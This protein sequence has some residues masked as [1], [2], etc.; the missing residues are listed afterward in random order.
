MAIK[1]Y[2]LR[3][4][5]KHTPFELLAIYCERQGLL[6]VFDALQALDDDNRG[7]TDTDFQDIHALAYEGGV[8]LLIEEAQYES[9]GLVTA[10]EGLKGHHA[11]AFFAF[12]H[13][14]AL[15]DVALALS[16]RD[17]LTHHWRKRRGLP[18]YQNPDFTANRQAF[19]NA[20]GQYFQSKEGRGRTRYSC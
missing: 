13:H 8:R 5:L 7:K 20:I 18:Q 1:H 4:F 12:L 14:R 9:I 16:C 3:I 10:F 2:E 6:A 15:F 17:N 19:E 11:K